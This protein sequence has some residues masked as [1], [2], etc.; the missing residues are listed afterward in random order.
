MKRDK[1]CPYTNGI[2]EDLKQKTISGYCYII[3][4]RCFEIRDYKKCKHYLGIKDKPFNS[5]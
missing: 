1:L 5:S 2:T 3:P 4:K